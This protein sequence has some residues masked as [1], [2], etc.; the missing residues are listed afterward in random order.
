M[1]LPH[2]IA[3]MIALG[4]SAV[5]IHSQEKPLADLEEKKRILQERITRVKALREKSADS[6]KKGSPGSKKSKDD[7]YLLP[8]GSPDW[9]AIAELMKTNQA[10]MNQNMRLMMRLQQKMM[11]MTAEDITENIAKIRAL[12]INDEIRINLE[13]QLIVL[14]SQKDPTAAMDL[15]SDSL[16]PKKRHQSWHLKSAFTELAKKDPAAAML[17]MD[18]QIEAGKFVSKS[19]DP[20]DN[21]RLDFESRLMGALFQN[22]PAAVHKRL[23]QFSKE[24]QHRILMHHHQWKKEGG[25]VT[26]EYLD[27]VRERG[28]EDLVPSI[29][30]DAVTTQVRSEGLSSASKAIAAFNLT[31]EEQKEALDSAVDNFSQRWDGTKPDLTEVYPW[32]QKEDPE[33]A[34][35]LTARALNNQARHSHGNLQTIF[36][37]AKDIATSTGESEILDQFMEDRRKYGNLSRHLSH[38]KDEKLREQFMTLYEADANGTK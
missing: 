5:W 27:L 38:F 21:P 12:E 17:W 3:P 10:G 1:K 23:D 22:D 9:E 2:L 15:A 36:E 8:D 31:P 13:S 7:Q 26:M 16:D 29:V 28:I 34:V 24:E 18:K 30:G 6:G 19:L 33:R 37:T 4:G 25:T 32:A 11:E 20:S 35:E 14:L